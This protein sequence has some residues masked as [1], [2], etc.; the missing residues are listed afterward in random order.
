MHLCRFEHNGQVRTGCVDGDAVRA[1]D[2]LVPRLAKAPEDH[3]M[4]AVMGGGQALLDEVRAALAAGTGTAIP[5]AGVRLLAPIANPSKIL[6]SWVNYLNPAMAKLPDTSI[7]FAK[8]DSAIIGPGDAIHLPRAGSDIV[9][10]PEMTVVIGEAGREI[11]EADA[12]DHVGG[13]TIVNDV[14]AF[15]HRLQILI[16]ATGPYMMAKT[17]DT[18]APMGPW[19][20]TADEIPGPH[21]LEVSQY[22]NGDLNTHASTS[23]AVFKIPALISYLSNFFELRPGDLILTGSL[24]PN[25]GKSDFLS[26]G[27]MVRIE[28]EGL[29]VLENPVVNA[30]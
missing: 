11:S 30:P 6:C 5:L 10:E 25:A 18:F 2:D 9:V 19:L 12:M 4:R 17:F 22:L 1:L 27:D 20:V 15:S 3:D 14:T 7:F 21:Y 29:G 26:D 13:Y 8:F 16:G 24:P 23:E 28:I